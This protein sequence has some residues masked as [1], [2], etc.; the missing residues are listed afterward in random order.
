MMRGSRP[1]FFSVL[2]LSVALNAALHHPI[3][4]QV[5]SSS[6]FQIQSDSVN[7]GGG[8][9]SSTNFAQE[10]TFGE[11]ATGVGSSTN[12]VLRAGYQQMQDSFLALSAVANV[13]MTPTIGGVSGGISNGSTT[14]SATTDNPAGYQ[15][16][17]AAENGPAM[18]NGADS[19]ADYVPSGDPDF[20]FT[21]DPTDS[22][23]GYSIG[24]VDTAD[25]FK[26]NGALCNVGTTIGPLD[27][28]DGL[29]TSDAVI[30]E[31]SSPNQPNGATTTVYFRVGIGGAVVQAP[32][33][34]TATTTITLLAL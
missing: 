32:G 33:E 10:S 4:A 21:T 18:Q 9:S 25:R 2:L 28:W 5:R 23:F 16:T 14:F 29:S 7:F 3:A 19:I 31:A 20:T 27:C 22:H 26:N 24:G 12:F 17:I 1:L 30:A 13:T 11:I 34:Y 8:F 6:N 15:L